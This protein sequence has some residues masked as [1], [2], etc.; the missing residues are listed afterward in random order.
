MSGTQIPTW[1]R[2]KTLKKRR[3]HTSNSYKSLRILREHIWSQN[4]FPD[5]NL[6]FYHSLWKQHLTPAIFCACKQITNSTPKNTCKEFQLL[7]WQTMKYL[8][9]FSLFTFKVFQTDGLHFI[10]NMKWFLAGLCKQKCRLREE[11][12]QQTPCLIRKGTHWA[13]FR[14]KVS[15]YSSCW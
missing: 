12:T 13:N 14:I 10:S 11:P 15:H 5:A 1:E 2:R 7:T 4:L 6:E 9:I 3:N 8:S